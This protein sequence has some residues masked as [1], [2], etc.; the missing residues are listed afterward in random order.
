MAGYLSSRKISKVM[1]RINYVKNEKKQENIMSSYNTTSTEFWQD[2]ARENRARHIEARAGGQCV[3]AR[4]IIVGI[5]QDNNITAEAI[6]KGF[7]KQYGVEC[8]VAIHQNNKNGVVNRHAHIIFAERTQLENPEIIGEKRATRN[9][10]YNA[11]G[12]KCKKAEAVKTVKK[13]DII[14]PG[15]I[16]NFSQKDEYLKSQKFIYD[17]KQFLLKETLGIDWNLEKDLANKEL[18]QK[19]IGKENKKAEFIQQS[20]NL[21]KDIKELCTLSDIINNKPVGETLKEFMESHKI[22]N[23]N[24]YN[25]EENSEKLKEFRKELEKDLETKA[26]NKKTE[27]PEIQEKAKNKVIQNNK[28]IQENTEK[29]IDENLKAT[30]QL[31]K[32]KSEIKKSEELKQK[33]IEEL[34]QDKHIRWQ[35]EDE[36]REEYEEEFKD[37]REEL[38]SLEERIETEKKLK[39]KYENEKFDSLEKSIKAEK[40]VE[41]ITKKKDQEQKELEELQKEKEKIKQQDL[42]KQQEQQ[43]KTLQEENTKIKK[44]FKW[45]IKNIVNKFIKGKITGETIEEITTTENPADQEIADKIYNDLEKEYQKQTPE[46]E[47]QNPKQEYQ[48]EEED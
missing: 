44:D 19:H 41:E 31:Q 4:E 2:L 36:M 48:G 6:A 5:P 30:E 13:G 38:K 40:K 28:E 3:E 47:N 15:V 17:V 45:I 46:K 24:A 26:I 20:N 27:D 43:I 25:Q 7:K 42:Y 33:A 32:T 9:Y 1:G 16:H 37:K 29:L 12:E 11:K 21:K 34:K 8:F 14:K 23:F 10:Y 35:V 18:S 22:Y 39:E